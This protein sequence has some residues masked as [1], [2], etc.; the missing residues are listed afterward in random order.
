MQ[1]WQV[2][3]QWSDTFLPEIKSILGRTFIGPAPIEEDQERNTD[4]IVL[5]MDAIRIACRIRRYEYW[6][7]Y[8]AQFTIREA[9]PTGTKTE[10]A[11]I[12]EGWGDYLFY[13]FSDESEEG[14][15]A[16]AIADLKVF[17]LWFM[18]QLAQR[19]GQLPGLARDNQDG[20]S[21]FRAFFW[22]ELPREFVVTSRGLNGSPP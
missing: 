2:D 7:R 9:R 11:K 8:G 19:A 18:R 12:I 3:K 6:E 17:R 14:L 16:Y 13:G 4:L 21:Q 10:L 1:V 22:K 5:K 20:S 15:H